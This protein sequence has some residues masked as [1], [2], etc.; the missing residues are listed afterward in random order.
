MC[1]NFDTKKTTQSGDVTKIRLKLV[2]YSK[3]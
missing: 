3:N 1:I 2:K